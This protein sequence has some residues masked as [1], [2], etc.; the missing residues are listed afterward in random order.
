MVEFR[1]CNRCVMDN[2]SDDTI[3][4][5]SEGICNYCT[6]ALGDKKKFIFLM[7]KA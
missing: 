4:F 7:K 1:R 6:D 3:V 5:D 2:S